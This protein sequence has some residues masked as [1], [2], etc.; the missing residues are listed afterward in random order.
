MLLLIMFIIYFIFLLC[1]VAA[2]LINL[3][4]VTG[5]KDRRRS[6]EP[7]SNTRLFIQESRVRVPP[8]PLNG[9]PRPVFDAVTSLIHMSTYKPVCCRCHRRQWT[10]AWGAFQR[11]RLQDDNSSTESLVF[12]KLPV[13]FVTKLCF[14]SCRWLKRTH[15]RRWQSCAPDALIAFTAHPTV[16]AGL[17]R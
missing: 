11:R 13:V 16:A 6:N 1:L 15:A 4:N 7:T 9:Q 8:E 2:A 14:P 10:S 17:K 3:L 5:V 12:W